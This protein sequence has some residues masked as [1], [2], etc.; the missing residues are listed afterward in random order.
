MDANEY[1]NFYTVPRYLDQGN[2]IMGFPA[3]E[4]F[5][6]III[7]G[8]FS[9]MNYMLTGAVV[10][11]VVGV[12]LHVLKQGHGDNFLSLMF[13]WFSPA[14]LTKQMFKKTPSPCR[15]YWLN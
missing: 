3:D 13:Y 5:P 4:V 11:G 15:K 6:V 9:L 2:V 10:G 7:F 14:A 12:G 8:I 1:K